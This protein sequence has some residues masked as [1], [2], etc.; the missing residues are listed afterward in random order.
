LLATSRSSLHKRSSAP[1][2]TQTTP[3][4]RPDVEVLAAGVQQVVAASEVTIGHPAGLQPLI[5]DLH[6]SAPVVSSQ[7][8]ATL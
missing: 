8:L 1:K 4:S 6:P 3:Q 7:Y 5:C 2:G